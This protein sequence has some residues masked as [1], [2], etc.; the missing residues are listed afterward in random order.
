MKRTLAMLVV[1]FSSF[2]C[3][4]QWAD[5]DTPW[6]SF[7]GQL[8]AHPRE[9]GAGVS[10]TRLWKTGNVDYK[11]MPALQG[12]DLTGF[13]GKARQEVRITSTTGGMA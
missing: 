4:A 9:T 12:V 2:A 7:M 6:P 3:A 10:V 8:A 11:R 5:T 1:A 13:R